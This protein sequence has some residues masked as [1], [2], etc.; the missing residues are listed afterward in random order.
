MVELLRLGIEQP[1]P[2][3]AQT[4]QV[5]HLRERAL[6]RLA[7]VGCA[8]ELLSDGVENGKF[9]CSAVRLGG[10]HAGYI[11]LGA[12]EPLS[13][14]RIGATTLRVSRARAAKVSSRVNYAYRDISVRVVIT[15]RDNTFSQG[16]LGGVFCLAR[17]ESWEA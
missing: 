12:R 11:T 9:A 4:E 7:H 13:Y 15:A 2:A 6:E 8:V 17:A 1:D 14:C 3:G 5:R 10:W 16:P